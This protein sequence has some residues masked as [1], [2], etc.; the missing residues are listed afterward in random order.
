VKK[1]VYKYNIHKDYKFVKDLKLKKFDLL[2]FDH[3]NIDPK[4]V[5]PRGNI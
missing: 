4:V 2:Y 5:F 1:K 3:G